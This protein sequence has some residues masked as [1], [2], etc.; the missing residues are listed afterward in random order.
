MKFR[1][2][3]AVLLCGAL[4]GACASGAHQSSEKEPAQFLMSADTLLFVDF[5]AD[6]DLRVSTA[7]V[8]AGV[9]AAFARADSDGDGILQPVEF[10]T[11]SGDSLGGTQMPPYRLEFDRNVDNEI[12]ADEFRG[13]LLARA[14]EYD[15]NEDGV[16]TR[17][18][19]LRPAPGAGALRQRGPMTGPPPGGEPRRRR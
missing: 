3:A 7:E 4:L 10:A 15:R 19:F 5:D 11:W 1:S 12:T 6:H 18:E 14:K 16:I 2:G 17:A 9:T 8:E 13:E